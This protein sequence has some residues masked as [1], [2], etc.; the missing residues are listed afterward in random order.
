MKRDIINETNNL[1]ARVKF[2]KDTFL[3]L[4]GI[5]SLGDTDTEIFSDNL[6]RFDEMSDC[7]PEIQRLFDVSSMNLANSS[8]KI[9]KN[10]AIPILKHICV[11]CH[12]PFDISKHSLL[13]TLA[14]SAS[15]GSDMPD[16]P[17]MEIMYHNMA[18]AKSGVSGFPI[19]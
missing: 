1:C 17:L 11:Q 18:R 13:H 3:P 10:N 8:Y 6:T 2:L 19:L 9:T 14:L 5:S 4:Y 16:I 7:V 15:G 12:I